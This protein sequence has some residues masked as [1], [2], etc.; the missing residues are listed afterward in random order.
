MLLDA[1]NVRSIGVCRDL[2]DLIVIALHDLFTVYGIMTSCVFYE[3]KQ[4]IAWGEE[5][6]CGHGSEVA[7][8]F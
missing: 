2:V 4:G 6:G 3:S 1:H 7:E 5:E 8:D